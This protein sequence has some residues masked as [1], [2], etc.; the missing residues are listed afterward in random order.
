MGYIH[1]WILMTKCTIFS[2]ENTYFSGKLWWIFVRS[3]LNLVYSNF[4]AFTEFHRKI[5]Y[6]ICGEKTNFSPLILHIFPIFSRPGI[7]LVMH[8]FF[9]R[10]CYCYLSRWD[11]HA[12]FVLSTSVLPCVTLWPLVVSVCGSVVSTTVAVVFLLLSFVH[13]CS[14]DVMQVFS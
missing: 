4:T 8:V 5:T 9:F 13:L 6:E 3:P 2:G 11:F 12:R 10:C 7:D 1:P 14:C